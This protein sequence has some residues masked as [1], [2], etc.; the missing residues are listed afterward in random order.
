MDGSTLLLTI[1]IAALG[2]ACGSVPVGVLESQADLVEWARKAVA[3]ARTRPL[4]TKGKH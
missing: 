4:K 1:V 3:V 2:Y